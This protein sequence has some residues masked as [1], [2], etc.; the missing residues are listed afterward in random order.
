MRPST[1]M[2]VLGRKLWTPA[3]L[4][5]SLALWLDADDASTIT[6]NG[7]TVS[8]WRDKSGNGRHASQPNKASQPIYSPSR[9]NG[10]PAVFSD[11]IDDIMTFSTAIIPNN[12]TI[13]TVSQA[14]S[15]SDQQAFII[16]QMGN[17]ADVGRT[18]FWMPRS[19]NNA[20]IQ[21][22]D[23][24]I[25]VSYPFLLNANI[26]T[27][28]ER[29]STIATI[30]VNGTLL[31]SGTVLPATENAPTSIFGRTAGNTYSQVTIGELIIVANGAST[32]DRQ[33]LE[34]YLAHK[35]NQAANLPSD[36]PFRFTPPFV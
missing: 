11:G 19:G 21:V 7:S 10:R 9:I 14:N 3:A 5:S 4:G 6:L 28:W 29:V 27:S 8:E 35:R 26:I 12:F 22:G 23:S 25:V 15:N 13:I 16:S 36:H 18:Q 1:R 30:G 20:G 33:R 31:G 24:F 34:G 2:V 17:V 32:T